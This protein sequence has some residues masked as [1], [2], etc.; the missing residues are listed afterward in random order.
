MALVP[1]ETL[2]L[3]TA[4]PPTTTPLLPFRPWADLP[5]DLLLRVGDI[6]HELKCY[7]SVRGACAAWHRTLTPLTPSLLVVL[8]SATGRRP[9][10]TATSTASLHMRRSFSLRPVP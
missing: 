3:T 6:L 7:A 1:T 4:T 2:G 9:V 8:D 10:P 5:V